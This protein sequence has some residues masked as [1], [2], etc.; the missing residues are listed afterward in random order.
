MPI[1]HGISN[2]ARSYRDSYIGM[3]NQSSLDFRSYQLGELGAVSMT[4][5]VIPLHFQLL[6]GPTSLKFIAKLKIDTA[7]APQTKD[8]KTVTK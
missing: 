6:M 2:Q 1:F 4:C 3:E 8:P 5:K 7:P